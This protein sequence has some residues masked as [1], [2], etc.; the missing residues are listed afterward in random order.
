MQCPLGGSVLCK[1]SAVVTLS[2]MSGPI[3]N[4]DGAAPLDTHS[5]CIVR[6]TNA[7]AGICGAPDNARWATDGL[8]ALRQKCADEII[9]RELHND[10]IT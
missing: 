2:L 6:D 9:A 4:T 3:V 10:Y 7:T 5:Q 1:S 8:G